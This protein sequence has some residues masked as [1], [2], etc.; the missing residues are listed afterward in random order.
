MTGARGGDNLSTQPALDFRPYRNYADTERQV[1]D[2]VGLTGIAYDLAMQLL[3]QTPRADLPPLPVRGSKASFCNADLVLSCEWLTIEE[4]AQRE[5][6]DP[7]LVRGRA[8]EG[9]LGPVRKN[10]T[11]EE[12][13]IWPPKM[14]LTPEDQL[15]PV[16]KKRFQIKVELPVEL[17]PMDMSQLDSTR[18]TFLHLAHAIGDPEQAGRQAERHAAAKRIS[19][20][21]DSFRGLP[22]R[23]GH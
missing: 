8:S 18:A 3:F 14:A 7:S 1:N 4:Y 23:G 9:K 16:D 15:P 21:V 12:H 5:G 2:F 19:P 13:V 17:D 11:G 22:S 6:I 20:S 10:V